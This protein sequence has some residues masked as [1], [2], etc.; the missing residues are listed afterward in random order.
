LGEGVPGGEERMVLRD[1][2]ESGKGKLR[3]GC[4]IREKEKKRI[5]NKK[6]KINK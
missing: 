5:K 6:I 1:C 4:T 2:R 3:L